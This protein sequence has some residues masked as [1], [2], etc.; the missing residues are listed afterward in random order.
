MKKYYLI[1]FLCFIAASLLA[2]D[3][4]RIQLKLTDRK[5]SMVYLA[6]YY[7]KNFPT[8]YKSD[9]A[10]LDKNG[11]AVFEKKRENNGRHIHDPSL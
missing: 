7:G 6:H 11:N 9:S 2:K 8:V 5:D 10:K 3:G 1:T 4:Y